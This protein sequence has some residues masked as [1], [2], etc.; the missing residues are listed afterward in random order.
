MAYN[1]TATNFETIPRN[2]KA[3][4]YFHLKHFFIIVFNHSLYHVYCMLKRIRHSLGCVV[5][6]YCAAAT[7]RSPRHFGYQNLVKTCESNNIK[8]YCQL[9]QISLGFG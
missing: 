9:L 2:R 7:F 5:Y 3:L 4:R 6:V 1:A 8:Q